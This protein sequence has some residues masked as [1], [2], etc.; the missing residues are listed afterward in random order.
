MNHPDTQYL[1]SKTNALSQIYVYM[2]ERNAG[3]NAKGLIYLL[4]LDFV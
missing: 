3:L 4:K 2:G 1:H